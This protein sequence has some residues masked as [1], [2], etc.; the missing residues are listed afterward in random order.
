MPRKKLTWKPDLQHEELL[1]L[2]SY[3][4]DTGIFTWIGHKYKWRNGTRAGSCSKSGHRCIEIKAV[5]YQAHR[6]AWFYVTGL[7]PTVEI[8]HEDRVTDNNRFSNLRE[9]S[10]GQQRANS[11]LYKNNTS[12]FRG[13]H[14]RENKWR[15]TMRVGPGRG[16][17]VSI[18]A[19][20]LI[21]DAVRAYDA[22]A[23]ERWGAFYT[24][25]LPPTEK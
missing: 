3:D 4:K 2:L 22:A 14:K 10:N 13:V 6:L 21:E 9:A 11:S 5:C 20:D 7:W 15:A 16:K 18:G 23:K 12:G 8:D 17:L 1:R 24:P 25:Q 19:F